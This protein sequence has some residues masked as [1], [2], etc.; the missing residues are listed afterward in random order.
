MHQNFISFA[1]SKNVRYLYFQS[2]IFKKNSSVYRY[3]IILFP[4]PTPPP[5]S[6]SLQQKQFEKI[7]LIKAQR[8]GIQNVFLRIGKHCIEIYMPSWIFSVIS[9]DIRC[10]LSSMSQYMKVNG[11]STRFILP[12]TWILSLAN[13]G[14]NDSRL[15]YLGNGFDNKNDC[16][17]LYKLSYCVNMHISVA[18]CLISCIIPS[19]T[20]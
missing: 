8:F 10:L 2:D 16:Y 7:Y 1:S 18:A 20:N 14:F 3:F 6:S 4:T 12:P 5:R 11:T 9:L 15:F 17:S 19:D 13:T